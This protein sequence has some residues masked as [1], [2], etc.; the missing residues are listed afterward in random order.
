MFP[1]IED[2]LVSRFKEALTA[3]FSATERLK[4]DEVEFL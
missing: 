4:P 3:H 1:L 2:P